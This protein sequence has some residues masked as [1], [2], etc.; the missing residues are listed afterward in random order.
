MATGGS[1]WAATKAQKKAGRNK[2]INKSEKKK[3][4]KKNKRWETR[5]SFKYLDIPVHSFHIFSS[6]PPEIYK[7]LLSATLTRG[8][9]FFPL[10][11]VASI[12]FFILEFISHV[13][14]VLPACHWILF[15]CFPH[16]RL[17]LFPGIRSSGR[18]LRFP[19]GTNLV[20]CESQADHLR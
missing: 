3:K 12:D 1:L 17:N 7:R 13:K 11:T 2:Q 4:K 15:R 9:F 19:E 5:S 20:Y 10:N 6:F 14:I 8:L 16:W 18:F